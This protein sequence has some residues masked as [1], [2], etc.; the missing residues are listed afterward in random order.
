MGG[1]QFRGPTCRGLR[2][3]FL[4]V[5]LAWVSGLWGC[6][7]PPIDLARNPALYQPSGYHAPRST[8]EAVYL[9]RLLDRREY[10]DIQDGGNFRQIYS[11]GDWARLVPLMV[12]EVLADEIGTSGIYSAVS[13]NAAPSPQEIVIEP[14]LVR[15]YRM[16][17]A[18]I[19]DGLG[20]MRRTLAHVGLHLK[21]SG[22]VGADGQRRVLLEELIESEVATQPSLS[23]PDKALVLA[24]MAL[25]GVMSKA[26]VLL[27][28]S[29][30][31]L[32]R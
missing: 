3:A 13:T 18:F 21:V 2:G 32:S 26:M 10:P 30:V 1:H 31:V 29:N 23:R 27:Y 15:M 22:P 17:E 24:G 7:V 6:A 14:T 4:F 19:G 12:E 11:E 28:E 16:R 25:R 9:G 20:G 5:G 8:V